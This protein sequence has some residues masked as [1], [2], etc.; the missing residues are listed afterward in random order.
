MSGTLTAMI[1]V[2]CYPPGCAGDEPVKVTVVS[3]LATTKNRTVDPKL[4]DLAKEVQKR[5]PSLTGF[6]VHSSEAKSIPVGKSAVFKLVE[7]QE[8]KVKVER[9][10]DENGRVSLTIA[11]PEVGEITYACTCDRF[12]PVVTP[13]RT[14][15]GETLIVIV[16]AKPCA[17]K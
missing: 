15:K 4:I 13:Y 5:D 16:M 7:K 12:F 8:L 11:P 9:P 2:V 17:K 14:V 6:R 10:K 1:L 3:V